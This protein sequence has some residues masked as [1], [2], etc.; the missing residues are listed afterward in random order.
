MDYYN[1]QC[2]SKRRNTTTRTCEIR[3]SLVYSCEAAAEGPPRAAERTRLWARSG[4][5]GL[6]PAAPES[7]VRGPKRRETNRDALVITVHDKR[8]E[9]HGVTEVSSVGAN[10]CSGRGSPRRERKP[11]AE[12]W[13]PSVSPLTRAYGNTDLRHRTI[14]PV[15]TSTCV[16]DRK[17]V[18]KKCIT[19]LPLSHLETRTRILL[20][21]SHSDFLRNCRRFSEW[22][23]PPPLP[24]ETHCRELMC[25]RGFS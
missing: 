1:L 9:S 13:G 4:Q 23:S 21:R 24:Q 18:F 12:G 19:T 22:A 20:R 11:R 5:P 3:S 14:P 15:N 16:Y 7:A 25:H 17:G 10:T 2:T 6:L 8:C